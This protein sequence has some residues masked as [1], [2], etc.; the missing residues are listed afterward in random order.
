MLVVVTTG[1]AIRTSWWPVGGSVPANVRITRFIPYDLLLEH[2][3]VF[4]TNGGYSGV[5]LALAHGVPIVQAGVTEE[6]VEIAARIEWTGVGVKLG[7]SRPTPQAVHAGVT[8]VLARAGIRRGGEPGA[9][10]DGAS[11]TPAG[12]VPTCS[13]N[14]PP[15]AVWCPAWTSRRSRSCP[16]GSTRNGR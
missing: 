13:S 5:T 7:T 4:V 3:D 14:W 10:G 12:K 11:T 15:P 6:K 8:R 16:P 9:P 2:T 1:R